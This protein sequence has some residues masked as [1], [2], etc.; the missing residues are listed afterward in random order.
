MNTLTSSATTAATT[1]AS[2][3]VNMPVFMP[4]IMITGNSKAQIASRSDL[5]KVI[6][7]K[8]TEG[9]ASAKSLRA[10]NFQVMTSDRAMIRPGK[11]P[12]KNSLVIDN[13]AATPNSTNGIAGG[14]IGAIQP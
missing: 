11:I 8:G 14:R 7:L 10:T 2:V 13:C 12:A 5:S 9:G 4:P 6:K 1:A 3:G